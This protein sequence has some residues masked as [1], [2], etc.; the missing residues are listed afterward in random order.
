MSTGQDSG[1]NSFSQ[2]GQLTA[3][4]CRAV[5]VASC[6]EKYRTAGWDE[7]HTPPLEPGSAGLS[8][9]NLGVLRALDI[10]LRRQSPTERMPVAGIPAAGKRLGVRV[11][12]RCQL[13]PSGLLL[14]GSSSSRPPCTSSERVR[15]LL[16]PARVNSA[17]SI[18]SVFIL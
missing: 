1:R 15:L 9:L 7:S 16:L 4:C 17:R 10:H 11:K 3:R 13:A 12:P 6:H 18:I 2:E 5:V 14:A 8:H